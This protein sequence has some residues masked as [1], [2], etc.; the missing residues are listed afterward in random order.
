MKKL[1]IY[2]VLSLSLLVPSVADA[3]T[4][5]RIWGRP[6]LIGGTKSVDNILV[7]VDG[8]LAIVV[9]SANTLYFYRFE[10]SNNDSEG[11]YIAG[12]SPIEPDDSTA[13]AWELVQVQMFGTKNVILKLNQDE[14]LATGN[15]Q[16][17]FAVPAEMNNMN[18]IS[19]GAHVYAASS[20]GVPTIQVNNFTDTA[21]MLTTEIEIDVSEF[22]SDDAEGGWAIDAAND[23]IATGDVICI[24]VDIAGTDTEG[25]EVRLGFRLP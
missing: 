23:D 14:A 2:L 13:G 11:D 9:D 1:F 6:V 24:D 8:D 10:D 16:L 4:Y 5:M 3:A 15:K 19:A 7:P 18:L 21:D 25:L 22:D 17:C 12:V 20:S